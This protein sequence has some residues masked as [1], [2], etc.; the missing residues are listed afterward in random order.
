MFKPSH[1][2]TSGKIRTHTYEAHSLSQQ[3]TVHSRNPRKLSGRYS[4][5]TLDSSLSPTAKEIAR[6]REEVRRLRVIVGD[7]A[8]APPDGQEMIDLERDLDACEISHGA[9][10]RAIAGSGL[11]ASSVAE[12]DLD[13]DD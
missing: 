13:D 10:V 11:R 2:T 5:N 6:L 7:E 9:F 12:G 1:Y 8:A 3:T 4:S